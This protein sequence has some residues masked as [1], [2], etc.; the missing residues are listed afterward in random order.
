[1]GF[2]RVALASGVGWRDGKTRTLGELDELRTGPIRRGGPEAGV[3]HARGSSVG[4]RW[5]RVEASG[6]A[7]WLA[8]ADPLQQPVLFVNPRSG[9]G[10]AARAGVAERARELG[11]EVVILGAGVNLAELVCVAVENGADALGMAGGDGSLSVVADAAAANGLPFVCIPAGTRNHFAGDLGLD[12]R[13]PGRGA[14]R[15][16]RRAREPD[17]PGRG[18]QPPVPQQRIARRVR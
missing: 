8:A 18:E 14:W 16:R 10:A 9:N 3:W 7:P 4:I 15:V 2:L 17:R 12:R 13:R 6:S 5:R 11:I 1:M